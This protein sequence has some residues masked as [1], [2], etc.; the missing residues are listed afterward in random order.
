VERQRQDLPRRRRT[1]SLAHE[2]TPIRQITK[3]DGKWTVE[4]LRYLAPNQLL[5]G[6]QNPAPPPPD[7]EVPGRPTQTAA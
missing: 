4:E 6:V 1:V 2:E 5:A 7:L 3:A